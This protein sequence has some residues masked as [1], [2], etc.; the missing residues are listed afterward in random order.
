[1]RVKIIR[2]RGYKKFDN[3]RF[4]FN[5]AKCNFGCDD[6]RTFKTEVSVYSINMLQSK[7]YVGANGTLFMT[8]EI[9]RR[10]S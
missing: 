7:K 8:E 1:M 10:D 9:H 6:L 2:Y 4:R 3:S 5:V